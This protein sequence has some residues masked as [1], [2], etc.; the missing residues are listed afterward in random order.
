MSPILRP[1]GPVRSAAAVNE[2]IRRLWPHPAVPLSVEDRALYERLLVEWAV[3][4]R[5]E[6]VE[7][8]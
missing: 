1:E 5:A 4:V 8:A 7:A 3:A 6:I 2:E